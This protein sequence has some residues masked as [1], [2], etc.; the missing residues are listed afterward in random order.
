MFIVVS[1]DISDD[2]RRTRLHHTLKNFG[3]PVQYSVFECVLDETQ[4][5][6]MKEAVAKVIKKDIDLVRY[7]SL[8]QRCQKHIEATAH[9]TVTH[10]VRTLVI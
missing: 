7:Y 6:R 8:C 5:R 4:F 2:K 1:Y 3:T 9:A 10:E